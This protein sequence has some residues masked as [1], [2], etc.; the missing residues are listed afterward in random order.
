[1]VRVSDHQWQQMEH[2]YHMA[3]SRSYAMSYDDDCLGYCDD[4]LLPIKPGSGSKCHCQCGEEY[5]DD[6]DDVLPD[7]APDIDD[8]LF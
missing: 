5:E 7:P 6:W 4:C 8:Y 1:M 3:N 2:D